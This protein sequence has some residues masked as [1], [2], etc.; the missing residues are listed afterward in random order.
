MIGGF[1]ASV[2]SVHAQTNPA[3]VMDGLMGEIRNEVNRDIKS[4]IRSDTREVIGEE[5]I[6][7]SDTFSG[8]YT[9]FS[10]MLVTCNFNITESRFTADCFD[11]ESTV[12][13]Q[14]TSGSLSTLF[15][16]N[17][18][19]NEISPPLIC[20]GTGVAKLRSGDGTPGTTLDV[21][22]NISVPSTCNDMIDTLA[23]VKQ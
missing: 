4:N 21:T 5:T 8:R 1:I 17:Y 23:F 10:D 11:N 7:P 20:T 15:N 13:A 14:S 3:D 2:H 18:T 6:N 22:I 9:A 12:V 16:F 19:I